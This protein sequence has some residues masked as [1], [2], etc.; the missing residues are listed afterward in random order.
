MDGAKG[1]NVDKKENQEKH[2]SRRR[3][4]LDRKIRLCPAGSPA[5]KYQGG[6]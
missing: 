5:E 4:E 2:H 1:G 6:Q 3:L